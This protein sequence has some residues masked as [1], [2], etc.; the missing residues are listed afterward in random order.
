M[1][2][3]PLNR[4]PQKLN[5]KTMNQA[6]KAKEK[7]LTILDKLNEEELYSFYAEVKAEISNRLISQQKQAEDK[8][9]ELQS[10]I[11]RIQNT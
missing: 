11:D 3:P 9:N 5:H 4:N 8:A 6:E 2:Q 7:L 10:K 1:P